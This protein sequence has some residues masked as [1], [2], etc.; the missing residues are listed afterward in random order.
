MYKDIFFTPPKEPLLP[1]LALGVL[2]SHVLLIQ[3]PAQLQAVS[4]CLLQIELGLVP[5]PGDLPHL[6]PADTVSRA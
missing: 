1:E 5:L 2:K 6:A 4:L 3:L